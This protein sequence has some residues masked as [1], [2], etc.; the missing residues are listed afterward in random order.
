MG[1]PREVLW[2]LWGW[3]VQ[4]HWGLLVQ[5]HFYPCYVSRDLLL[6][7]LWVSEGVCCLVLE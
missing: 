3:V 5:L 1:E 6:W 2:G 7:R 4:R